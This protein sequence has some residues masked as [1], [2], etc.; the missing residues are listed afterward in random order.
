MAPKPQPAPATN[1]QPTLV[2]ASVE[3]SGPLPPPDILAGYGHVVSNGAERIM[4]MAERE[5]ANR[6][7]LENKAADAELYELKSDRIC[8]I[9]GQIAALIV[10]VGAFGC[11]A[12][13][14]I[15]G[16]PIAGTLT[17]GS[18]ITAIVISFLKGRPRRP[19]KKEREKSE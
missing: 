9:I 8:A 16:Y 3:Y 19:P 15:Y 2:A 17:A 11:A 13:M 14:A 5:Q 6:H 18:T 4:V 1:G 10:T 12:A 7:Q